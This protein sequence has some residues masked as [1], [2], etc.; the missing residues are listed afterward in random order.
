MEAE[1]QSE[2]GTRRRWG[3]VGRR[4]SRFVAAYGLASSMTFLVLAA[5]WAVLP[6]QREFLS[7]EGGPIEALTALIYLA[8]VALSLG[9]L[10]RARREGRSTAWHWLLAA[11]CL[12]AAL[13]EVSYGYG[14]I[15]GLSV[16]IVLGVPVD[17]AHDVIDVARE[18]IARAGVRWTHLAAVAVIVSGLAVSF[19][20]SLRKWALE[21]PS[22]GIGV[23]L[24]AVAVGLGLV[25]QAM[26]VFRV[27][28]YLEETLE[29]EAALTLAFAAASGATG[30]PWTLPDST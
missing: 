21:V 27:S 5:L 16:P 1:P 15:P 12:L 22:F 4:P 23:R 11:L 29:L 7:R 8:G 28:V 30:E 25:A 13:D 3:L 18:V 14:T 2:V 9:T 26:D 24:V 19:R 17:S 10:P 6:G 20:R